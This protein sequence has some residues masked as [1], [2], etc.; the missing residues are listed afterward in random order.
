MV[1]TMFNEN[2]SIYA[3]K[4]KS[5]HKN[6]KKRKRKTTPYVTQATKLTKGEIQKH[7]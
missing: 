4:L 3:H 7:I 2:S 1:Y 6:G 5:L